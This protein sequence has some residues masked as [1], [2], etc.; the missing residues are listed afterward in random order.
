VAV[1]LVWVV[2]LV[3]IAGVRAA[4]RMQVA[5]TALKVLPLLLVGVAGAA[6]LTPS[7]FAVPAPV[8]ASV[9]TSLLATVT[10]TLW[11]FLG[12]ECA[13]IPAGS[14][15]DPSRTIPRATIIG[16]LLA[17]AIYIL[18]TIGVMGV[19]PPETLATSTAPFADAAGRLFGGLA[20]QVVAIGAAISCLGALNG[21]VLMVGQLPLAVARDGLFPRAFMSVGRPE[22]PVTGMIIA[23]MLSTVLVAMN[24]TRG[25]VALFNFIILLAVL[26]TLVPYVLCSLAVFIGA[27]DRRP[28]ARVTSGLTT[29]AAVAFLYSVG[30]VAGA[31]LEAIGWGAALLAG[32][33]PVFALIARGRPKPQ[34]A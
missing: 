15:T 20:A 13:T 24:Y 30:A 25:L 1:G 2:T 26:S 5:T 6:M 16:T 31:G 10:L 32:G 8:Q 21:W 3:N 29:I 34:T 23:A 33:I 28:A 11:A 19:V 27:G 4:G 7:H 14:V 17:A 22:T 18:S 12:L 9:T